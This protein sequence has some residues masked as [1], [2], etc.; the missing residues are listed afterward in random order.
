MDYYRNNKVFIIFL[1]F[2]NGRQKFDPQMVKL[3]EQMCDG[4]LVRGDML[5]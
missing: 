2:S 4:F 5:C 3:L 1:S